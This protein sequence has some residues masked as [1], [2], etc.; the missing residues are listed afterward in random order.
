[1][2]LFKKPAEAPRTEARSDMLLAANEGLSADNERL[3]AENARLTFMVDT[4]E[5]LL[6]SRTDV[7]ALLLA[8]DHELGVLKAENARLQAN[9]DW[10]A[11]HVNAIT[12]ERGVLFD[13]VLNVTFPAV[14]I[15]AREL[16]GADPAYTPTPVAGDPVKTHPDPALGDILAKAREIQDAARR[17]PVAQ[18][19]PLGISFEDMGDEAAARAG[20]QHAPDGTLAFE[21]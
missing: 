5:H 15:I 2:G 14:P 11:S 16:P 4:L 10:L 17:G 6:K 20:I 13:K 8:R 7:A 3:S 1:M 12:M 21:R 9:F 19:E 18:D